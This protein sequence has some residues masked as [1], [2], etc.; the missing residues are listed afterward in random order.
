[1][2]E[3][4]ALTEQIDNP[5]NAVAAG[6]AALD[7]GDPADAEAHFSRAI[8]DNPSHPKA[9]LFHGRV[10]IQLRKYRSALSDLTRAISLAPEDDN[11]YYWRGFA[12]FMLGEAANA[13][14][15]LDTADRKSVV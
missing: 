4:T 11:A 15:D 3:A 14:Q 1:M 9:Y 2:L 6:Q 12:H 8:A 5:S 7:A 10:L 13:R